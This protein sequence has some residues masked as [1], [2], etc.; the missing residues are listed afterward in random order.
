MNQVIPFG[1][2]LIGQTEKTLN[3]IL[4]RLLVGSGVSEPQWVA[5]VTIRRAPAWSTEMGDVAATLKITHSEVAAKVIAPLRAAGLVGEAD[6]GLTL[7]SEG[8]EFVDDIRRRVAEITERLWGDIP[9][10]DLD[11]AASVLSL[12]GER[13][14]DELAELSR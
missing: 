6:G 12:V 13:A 1:T 3:A 8:T 11:T 7:T 5:L 9:Q 10:A 2:R 14:H 4:E